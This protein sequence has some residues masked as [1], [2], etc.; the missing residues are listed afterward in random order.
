MPSFSK[1]PLPSTTTQPS[2]GGLLKRFT[3]KIRPSTAN[4][5]TSTTSS[6]HDASPAAAS[7]P[8]ATVSK[9]KRKGTIMLPSM[10]RPKAPVPALANGFTSQQQR[11]AALFARG[12]VPP[13]YRDARGDTVPMS[14]QEAQMDNRFS[15]LLEEPRSSDSSDGESEAR[16]IREAWL[17]RNAEAAATAYDSD[18]AGSPF[19]IDDVM[20]CKSRSPQRPNIVAEHDTPLL[21][22]SQAELRSGKSELGHGGA[23]ESVDP[24]T[25]PLP[26]TPKS[27]RTARSKFGDDDVP[28]LPGTLGSPSAPTPPPKDSA[29]APVAVRAESTT[30]SRKDKSAPPSISIAVSTPPRSSTSSPHSQLSTLPRLP[31]PEID[32]H[33]ARSATLPTLHITS[34][35]PPPIQ[36]GRSLGGKSTSSRSVPALSPT[37]TVDS[38]TTSDAPHTPTMAASASRMRQSSISGESRSSED[39]SHI[40]AVIVEC[41]EDEGDVVAELPTTPKPLVAIAEKEIVVV[42]RKRTG[43]FGK[44]SVSGPVSHQNPVY[45]TVLT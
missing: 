39:K 42:E 4:S 28:P 5:A 14:E 26:A 44:R 25:I 6:K 43:L 45:R 12:L 32:F 8:Q 41:P 13:R 35:S 37:R 10:P 2:K 15:V 24:T 1:P 22:P 9:P 27:T 40:A 31:S 34:A 3:T 36:R 33:R 18:N 23:L 20:I 21:S 19:A 11:E 30:G 16:R 29:A 7:S 17:K 38:I